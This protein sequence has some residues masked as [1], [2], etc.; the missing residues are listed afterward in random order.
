MHTPVTPQ[1]LLATIYRHLQI[2]YR[3]EFIN[4]AGWP[5]PVLSRGQP[6][7]QIL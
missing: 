3:R 1:N 2:D 6:V 4:F 5:V 7:S